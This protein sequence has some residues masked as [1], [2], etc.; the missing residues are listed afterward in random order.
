MD[1][2]APFINVK[3]YREVEEAASALLFELGATGISLELVEGSDI[4]DINAYG[5]DTWA[6]VHKLTPLFEAQLQEVYTHYNAGDAPEILTGQVERAQWEN[7]YRAF[8]EPTR[9][10]KHLTIAP[11][12]KNHREVATKEEVLIELNPGAAFGTGTHPTTVL[13]LY[14]L[15]QVMRG[16]ETVIDVGTGSGV[17]A[18]A[19]VA[20]GAEKVLATDND[21][22][23]IKVASENFEK[24]AINNKIEL[25]QNN[26]LDGIDLSA[27]I[28][29][30]NMLAEPLL[31]MLD[32]AVRLLKDDGALILSGI[33]Y[34]KYRTIFEKIESLGLFVDTHMKRDNWFCFIAKK[35]AENG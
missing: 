25:K 20:L 8:Y 35:E 30:A 17:L 33:Y 18:I 23:A 5:W 7:A 28:I 3:I 12:W 4:L 2:I 19:A 29:I 26:L 21:E 32:D 10:T 9:I 11:I 31:L 14:A 6:E 15:E 34:D 27:D 24:N 22:V 16:G 13:A 1:W